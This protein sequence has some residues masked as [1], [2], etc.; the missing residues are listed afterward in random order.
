MSE[1]RLMQTDRIWN[2]SIAPLFSLKAARFKIEFIADKRWR[3]Y[4][5]E[6]GV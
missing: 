3:I 1:N 2:E 5:Q 4:G 6:A